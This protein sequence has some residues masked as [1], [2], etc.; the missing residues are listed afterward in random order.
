[1]T[2]RHQA[3]CPLCKHPLI[4]QIEQLYGNWYSPAELLKIFDLVGPGKTYENESAAYRGIGRHMTA[5]RRPLDRR[6]RNGAGLIRCFAWNRT[7]VLAKADPNVL[8]LAG[9]RAL[10][11]LMQLELR[12]KYNHRSEIGYLDVRNMSNEQLNSIIDGTAKSILDKRQ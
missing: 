7:K 4:G 11:M 10:A 9:Q 2:K 1:V 8:V 12:T 6:E 5:S 3:N